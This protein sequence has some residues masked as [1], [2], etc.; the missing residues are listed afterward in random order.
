VVAKDFRWR[1]LASPGSASRAALIFGYSSGDRDVVAFQGLERGRAE[2][3]EEPGLEDGARFLGRIVE[4]QGFRIALRGGGEAVEGGAL[5]LGMLVVRLEAAAVVALFETEGRE[6]FLK[7]PGIGGLLGQGSF[8]DALC[9]LVADEDL[10]LEFLVLAL[11]LIGLLELRVRPEAGEVE[12]HL[13]DQRA[14]RAGIEHVG[15]AEDRLDR[16][17]APDFGLAVAG[18]EGVGEFGVEAFAKAEAGDAFHQ[19]G[20]FHQVA[21][22]LR[23]RQRD[24][25][26]LVV[27]A[28]EIH[29]LRPVVLRLVRVVVFGPHPDRLAHQRLRLLLVGVG[30]RLDDRQR[31]VLFLHLQVEAG[32]GKQALVAGRAFDRGEPLFL[33]LA[34]EQAA[35]TD[36]PHAGALEAGVRAAV[37]HVP[38]FVVLRDHAARIALVLLL[39]D[40]GFVGPLAGVEGEDA[41][42]R[43][44]VDVLAGE[45]GGDGGVLEL[46]LFEPQGFVGVLAGL[47]GQGAER[48]EQLEAFAFGVLEGFLQ[49][50]LAGV[51]AE[52]RDQ[53]EGAEEGFAAGFRRGFRV[54]EEGGGKFP[55][56]REG[57][58]AGF[59]LVELEELGAMAGD[60]VEGGV[61][62]LFPGNC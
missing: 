9:G 47:G 22:L 15:R 36:R 44:G 24:R 57:V 25:A 19:L 13:A 27:E 33:R 51:V 46:E 30:E 6:L 21:F 34:F 62:L 43:G 61:I 40:A 29:V 4:R 48:S 37:E 2:G 53:R 55:R 7:P 20:K 38:P 42:P 1:A 12:A 50:L 35:G 31:L 26:R 60:Q 10:L 49:P 23:T 28:V 54:G 16:F 59:L 58:L 18:D 14:E 39:G 11:G 45:Q 8:E 32:G 52:F 5:D 41:G 17:H 3:G 56:E